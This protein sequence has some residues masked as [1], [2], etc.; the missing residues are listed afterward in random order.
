MLTEQAY[1]KARY[2]IYR[3]TRPL[4]LSRWQYHF[5]N[6]SKENVL[7]ALSVYQNEDGG[8]GHALEADS[9]NPNSTPIQTWTAIEILHEIGFTSKEHPVI[10]GILRYLD[11]GADYDGRFWYNTVMSNNDYPH[12][13]WWHTESESS[14]HTDYNPTACLAGFA[15][16]YSK[17]N[18]SLYYKCLEIA[19]E[20]V[21]KYLSEDYLKDMHTVSCYIRLMEY[22]EESGL[23]DL[24][25]APILKQKLIKQVKVSITADTSLWRTSYICKPSQ[26][27][28]S[29]SSL[30]YNA[31]K[32]VA[33]Y[34][35]EYIAHSRNTDGIWDIT[36]S[37]NEYPKEWAITENWWKGNLAIL[38]M[39]YL[40]NFGQL[41]P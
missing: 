3:N 23:V 25:N 18:S 8:F 2:W 7:N 28:K 17:I 19:A 35:Y 34:E 12:A 41:L 36:W 38:N 27:L 6:G 29:P 32:E 14:S 11:S 4:D 9:W 40:K 15:L 5:E 30:F 20:A 16:C 26:F 24:F 39:L 21:R 1:H 31:N 22:C 37:W 13:P 10:K 33:D